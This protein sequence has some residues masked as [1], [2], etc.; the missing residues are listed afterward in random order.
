M[1]WTKQ[2]QKSSLN[3]TSVTVDL[4]IYMKTV[5]SGVLM[6]LELYTVYFLSDT[7]VS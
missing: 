1:Q 5:V 3:V 4:A 7:V 6:I 2:K